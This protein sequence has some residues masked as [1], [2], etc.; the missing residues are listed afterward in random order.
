M[1]GHR[2]EKRAAHSEEEVHG[3]ELCSTQVP[4]GGLWKLKGSRKWG[5]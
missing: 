1:A 4:K 3:M 5:R 2:V